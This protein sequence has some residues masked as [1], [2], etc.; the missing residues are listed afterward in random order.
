MAPLK[1]KPSC[2]VAA[3]QFVDAAAVGRIEVCVFCRELQN[4]IVVRMMLLENAFLFS[5]E[6]LTPNL[7][8]IY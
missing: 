2:A 7:M 6:S 5:F 8:F 1:K 4:V 3:L